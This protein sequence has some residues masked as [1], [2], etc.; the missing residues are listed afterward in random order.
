MVPAV[1]L[2]LAL[3]SLLLLFLTR[4]LVGSLAGV[5]WGESYRLLAA[6]PK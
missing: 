5:D 6:K 4:Y 2:A 1:V 3:V